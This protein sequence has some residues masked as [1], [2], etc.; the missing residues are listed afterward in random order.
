VSALPRRRGRER[1]SEEGG[2]RTAVPA[3]AGSNG[4]ERTR[5]RL[6]RGL[7]GHVLPREPVELLDALRRE[8]DRQVVRCGRDRILAPN[9][10]AVELDPEVHEELAGAGDRVGLL[11]TDRLARHGARNGYEWAGPLAVHITRARRVPGGRYRVAGRVMPHV[12]ADG[13]ATVTEQHPA[14]PDPAPPPDRSPP[15]PPRQQPGH[16][17]RTRETNDQ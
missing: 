13:F 17:S 10:Y 2:N 11:L 12:R 16:P 1:E 7:L 4:W 14:G 3:A 15:R 8:C 6:R 5:E 9:A